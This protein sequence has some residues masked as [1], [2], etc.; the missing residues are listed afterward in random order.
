MKGTVVDAQ[1]V[2]RC[3][4]CGAANSF[5]AQ[6]RRRAK[7]AF[8][9]LS[10]FGAPKLRCNGCGRFTKPG[11]GPEP[12]PERVSLADM[13]EHARE[14]GATVFARAVSGEHDDA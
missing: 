12:E 7:V 5:T 9:A 8:G 1:G 4:Y 14:R 6:R 2:V 13:T 3:P 10:L 11:D